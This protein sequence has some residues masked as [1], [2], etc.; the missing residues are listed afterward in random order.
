MSGEF[1]VSV[2]IGEFEVSEG[3][4]ETGVCVGSAHSR[5]EG[6]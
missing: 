4:E 1:G 6:L 3:C 5:L 2:G